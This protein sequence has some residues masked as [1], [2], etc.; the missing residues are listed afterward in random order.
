MAKTRKSKTRRNET[1][2]LCGLVNPLFR[3][4]K[5]QAEFRAKLFKA[6]VEAF[7]ASSKQANAKAIDELL[8]EL[9]KEKRIK[10]IRI[11]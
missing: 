5:K 6:Y 9:I 3:P 2:P 7:S 8:R 1:C 10:V 11:T 4:T